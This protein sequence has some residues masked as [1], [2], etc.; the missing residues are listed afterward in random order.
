MFTKFDKWF[1]ETAADPARRR[2]AIADYSKRRTLLFWCAVA[3][4]VCALAFFAVSIFATSKSGDAGGASLGFS[5][6]VM[7]MIGM[8]TDSDLRMLKMFDQFYKDRDDSHVA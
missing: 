5:A 7:W 8:K 4:S 3:S 6:A 2:A 1:A